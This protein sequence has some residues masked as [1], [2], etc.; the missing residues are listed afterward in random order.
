M[1]INDFI[2]YRRNGPHHYRLR[3]A[4]IISMLTPIQNNGSIFVTL[5]RN[6]QLTRRDKEYGN[7]CKS[8][9]DLINADADEDELLELVNDSDLMIEEDL[10]LRRLIERLSHWNEDELDLKEE[11]L[12]KRKLQYLIDPTID[13]IKDTSS[14]WS[15]YT[16]EPDERISNQEFYY[17]DYVLYN[18]KLSSMVKFE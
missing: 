14:S 6:D 13:R 2:V 5:K 17:P 4:R 8:L 16:M 18:S 9:S 1:L 12:I 10:I 11:D 7:A 3:D 15:T